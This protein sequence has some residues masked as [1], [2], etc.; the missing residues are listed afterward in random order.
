MPTEVEPLL[1]TADGV[2]SL[3]QISRRHVYTLL[4]SGRLPKPQKHG[5][6]TRWEISELRRWVAAG[7]PPR[8]KWEARKSGQGTVGRKWKQ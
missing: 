7:S 3:L 6:S 2:A 5:K 1:I 8:E 4:Q